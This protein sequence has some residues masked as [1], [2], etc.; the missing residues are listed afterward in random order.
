[1]KEVILN[2]LC[3]FGVIYFFLRFGTFL[4]DFQQLVRKA[5]GSVDKS[6]EEK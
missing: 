4:K 3:L 2:I 5:R 1:M 6:I